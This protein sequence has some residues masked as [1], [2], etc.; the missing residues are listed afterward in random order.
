MLDAFDSRYPA[1][2]T[3]GFPRHPYRSIETVT[4]LIEHGDS[5]GNKG[6][7][8]GGCCQWMTTGSGILH[9]EMPLAGPRMLGLQL[10]VNLP[11]KRIP[12]VS[13]IYFS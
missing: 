8:L 13:H 5:L 12:S 10:W 11:R 7:I 3:N 6:H 9:Q 2:Y 4:Y 1:D